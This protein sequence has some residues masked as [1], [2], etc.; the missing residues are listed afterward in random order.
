MSLASLAGRMAT[1]SNL[2]K[3]D[4]GTSPPG[5]GFQEVYCFLLRIIGSKRNVSERHFFLPRIQTSNTEMEQPLCSHENERH[6]SSK[7]EAWTFE[8]PHWPW[9]AW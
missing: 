2:E 8:L 9:F 7:A 3:K 5:R 4:V 1:Q 6:K